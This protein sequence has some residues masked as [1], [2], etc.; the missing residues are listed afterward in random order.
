MGEA[1]ETIVDLSEREIGEIVDRIL[2]EEVSL[3]E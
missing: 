1:T 2:G 3:Y